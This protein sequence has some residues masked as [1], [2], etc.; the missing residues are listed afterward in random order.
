MTVTTAYVDA[1]SPF[2]L[3]STKNPYMKTYTT[4][5]FN[6]ALA[7]AT[8]RFAR[9]D[10]GFQDAEADQAVGYLT[11][12]FLH[13]AFE[14]DSDDTGYRAGD[15]SVTRHVDSDSGE[16]TTRFFKLYRDMVTLKGSRMAVAT[17]G[18][19]AADSQTA[20]A[21]HPSNQRIPRLDYDDNSLGQP[22]PNESAPS[23]TGPQPHF[24]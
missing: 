8:A 14:G 11:C 12:H 2:S 21:L 20:R 24:P 22:T 10:P 6:Y 23:G 5:M 7:S 13:L 15:F 17:A 18:V 19:K 4:E 9:E 1:T 16:V 3:G